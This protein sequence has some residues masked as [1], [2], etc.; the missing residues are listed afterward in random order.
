MALGAAL[1]LDAGFSMSRDDLSVETA[2]LFGYERVGSRFR[3][4][5]TLTIDRLQSVG[6]VTGVERPTLDASL[7][8]VKVHLLSAVYST[9]A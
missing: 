9:H 6:L 1:I 4:R 5:V 8:K 2:R 3:D 7:P